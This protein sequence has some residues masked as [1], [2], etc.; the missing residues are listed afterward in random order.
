MPNIFKTTGYGNWWCIIDGSNVF[1]EKPK[2]LD[3]QATTWLDY[4]SHNTVKFLIGISPTGLITFLSGIYGGTASEKFIV[5]IVGF[6]T[7]SIV[8]MKL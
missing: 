8:M 3:T 2:K 6:L 5:V 1:I 7:A 4:K